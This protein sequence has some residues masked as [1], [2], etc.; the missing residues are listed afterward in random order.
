MLCVGGTKLAS[1]NST[2]A[3]ACALRIGRLAAAVAAIVPVRKV[4]RDVDIS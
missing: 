1:F 4:L 2:A 3:C